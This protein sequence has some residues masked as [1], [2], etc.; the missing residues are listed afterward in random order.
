MIVFRPINP[1]NNAQGHF[2]FHK[3]WPFS[4]KACWLRWKQKTYKA[5]LATTTWKVWIGYVSLNQTQQSKSK[6]GGSGQRP[7][8]FRNF[9]CKSYWNF[10]YFLFF[11]HFSFDLIPFLFFQN[12]SGEGAQPLFPTQQIVNTDNKQDYEI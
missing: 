8:N 11:P 12:I 5:L 4:L 10:I 7:R 1:L 2:D 6:N 9:L 3:I